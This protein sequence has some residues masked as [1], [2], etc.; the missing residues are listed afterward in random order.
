VEQALI[1]RSKDITHPVLLYVH[2]GPGSPEFPF[3]EYMDTDLEEFFTVCYWEQRGAGLS[4]DPHIP[5]SSMNLA[6]FIEDTREV[7]DYLRDKFDKE[8]IYIM[9]HSWGSLLSSYVIKKYP[10]R[11]HAYFGIGQ[12]ADQMRSE[13]L[14]YDFV[15]NEARERQDRKA[16]RQ[17]EKI[18][19]PPYSS[20]KEWGRALKTERKYVARYG[21]AVHNGNFMQ[22]AVSAMINCKAYRLKDK[23]NY[24]KGNNRSLELLWEELLDLNLMEDVAEQEIPVYIF[25]G[26]H[27]QQTNFDVA[28]DYFNI[29]EAPEKE[30]FVFENS[31]HSPN[32]E[33]KEKFENIIGQ[34]VTKTEE[35]R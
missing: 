3:V 28:R 10:E 21:G 26:R 15:L 11:Y 17:L 34:I 19:P 33:E 12:V 6:V 4:Y 31:A 29:L 32:Y 13:K 7:T 8:K 2:G 1:T 5:D 25:Q 30:F 20:E 14:S 16:V 24:M 35:A 18:G 23:F 22:I 27:D 9:G